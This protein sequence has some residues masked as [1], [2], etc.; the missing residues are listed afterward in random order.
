MSENPGICDNCALCCQHL[1]VEAN[2]IDVLREPRIDAARP[3]RKTRELSILDACWILARPGRP[4]S[5][6]TPRKRC[7]IYPTRPNGCVAFLPGSPKCQELRKEHGMP[8]AAERPG[9]HRI[10]TVIMKEALAAELDD[11]GV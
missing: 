3:L 9:I 6:L 5:F 11:P 4:C 1:V 8:P 2:A 7:E 10:L